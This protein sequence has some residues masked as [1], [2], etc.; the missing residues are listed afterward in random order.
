MKK[1]GQTVNKT[2]CSE[3]ERERERE[4]AR[5]MYIDNHTLCTQKMNNIEK[6]FAFDIERRYNTRNFSKKNREIFTKI[7]FV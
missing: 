1:Q 3:I 5:E 6:E 7:D 2:V 4:R